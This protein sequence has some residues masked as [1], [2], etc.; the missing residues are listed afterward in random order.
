MTVLRRFAPRVVLAVAMAAGP[1]PGQ[2]QLLT[3]D[4]ALALAFPGATTERLTAYLGEPELARARAL[5]GSDVEIES[6]VIAHYVARRGGEALGVAY[7]DAHRVR[8]EQEVLM[9]VV[10]ADDRVR[11]VETVSFREPPEYRAPDRWL[12]LLDSRVLSPELSLRGDIPNV[13]GA[14]LTSGAVTRA[15]RRVLA[16]HEVIDPLGT[17]GT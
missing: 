16:L 15:V 17:A 5:A 4:E 10:G 7:F 3:Q 2:A 8:T 6:T 11:R 9:V 1:L 14:T 13:T 12:R